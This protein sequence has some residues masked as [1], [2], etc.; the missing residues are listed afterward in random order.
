[1]TYHDPIERVAGWIRRPTP[2]PARAMAV[3]DLLMLARPA[4]DLR[5][6]DNP[7]WGQPRKVY[8]WGRMPPLAGYEYRVVLSVNED[9]SLHS[10]CIPYRIVGASLD[11]VKTYFSNTEW[12]CFMGMEPPDLNEVIIGEA[13]AAYRAR[14][15]RRAEVYGG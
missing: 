1:M 8:S 6:I 11:Y 14:Q 3:Q 9:G 5:I 15:K 12:R 10:F 13:E 7:G 4:D 2:L